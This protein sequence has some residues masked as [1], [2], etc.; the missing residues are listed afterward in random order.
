MKGTS[1]QASTDKWHVLANRLNISRSTGLVDCCSLLNVIILKFVDGSQK[2][3]VNG[4]PL[5]QCFFAAENLLVAQAEHQGNDGSKSEQFGLHEIEYLL[6]GGQTLKM[7]FYQRSKD[8][9]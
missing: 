3:I 7:D 1:T 9:L 5:L 2:I 4:K 8:S 6:F